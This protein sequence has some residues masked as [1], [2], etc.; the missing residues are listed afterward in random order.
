MIVSILI[1][2]VMIGVIVT[3]HEFG[4]FAIAK[5][6]GI[7]VLEFDIGMGPTLFHIQKGETDFCLKAFPFGG[8][9]IFDGMFALEDQDREPD[10]RSFLKANVY[11]RIATILAGPMMNFVIGFAISLI[12]VAFS[13]TDLPVVYDIMEDSAA[14]EA[15]ISAGDTIRKINGMNIHLYREVSLESMMNYGEELEITFEHEGENRTVVLTP[16]YDEEAG[17]YYIGLYGSGTYYEC[18]GPEILLYSFYETQYWARAT[19]MSLKSMVT[20][21]FHM[22]DLSGPVGI[23]KAVDDTYDAARPYGLPTV[24]LSMLNLACLLTVNLGIMN[25][26]PLPA[27]DG[28]RLMFLILEALRGK[29][30]SPEKEGY[31]HLA[32]ALL[33][34]GLV[35]VVLFNDISKFFR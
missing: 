25:L 9:C 6:S 14:E 15:G 1:F 24:I 31:V 2:L 34:F 16:K 27:L 22:D 10:E 4:H 12:V 30:V 13:G 35:I 20:G 23:V 28:G 5:R 32:G 3:G 26:L 19:F 29:P 21:H 7:R 33:L 18:S 17:R 8:A 11:S